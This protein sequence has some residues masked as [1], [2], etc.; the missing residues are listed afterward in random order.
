MN[1]FYNPVAVSF[2]AASAEAFADMLQNR[3][4]LVE[5]VL[6]LTRGGDVEKSDSLKS[7][8]HMLS[9]K[10]TLLKEVTLYNPNCADI[11]KLKQDI[12]PFGYEL[13]VAIGGGSVMDAA[14]VLSALQRKQVQTVAQVR[15]AI[16]SEW[17]RGESH[18]T[19]WIGI[20]T[21]SGT[22]SEVTCWATIWDEECGS[23]YSVSDVR[24]YA[25]EAL[26]L[27]ELTVTMPMRLS[28]ATALDAMCHATEAYWSVHTNTITRVYALQAIKRIRRTLPLLIE[29]PDDLALR[30]QL[31]TA[32]VLAGL[33]FS[34]TR[35]TACHSI[36]YPLTMLYGID[37][38]IAA[39]L[40]LAAVMRHNLAA[41]IDPE[42]LLHA[43]GAAD[44]DGVDHFIQSIYNQYGLPGR[45]GHYGATVEGIRH[46]VSLSYTKGRMDNNP[47][48]LSSEELERML[49]S[50]L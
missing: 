14:K 9:K 26:I 18:F 4:A 19:P 29:Q 28:V 10:E 31:S 11:L 3:Y 37:H 41:L 16:T 49:V 27:P 2:G 35:T 25:S 44:V 36:S 23:K 46:V 13:I 33:A 5:R 6:V 47:V 7:V 38:G 22:G 48:N 50:L 34:N 21:T 43:F 40:T 8:M 24:L 39:S 32:S 45:L 20:P 17:Y 1:H 42:K 15:E 30:E 12:E